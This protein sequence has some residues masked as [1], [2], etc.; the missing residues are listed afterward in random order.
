MKRVAATLALAVVLVGCGP[1]F[2]EPSL[3]EP[4]SLITTNGSPNNEGSCATVFASGPLVV[5]PTYGTAII[6]PS[7]HQPDTTRPI[8]VAWRPG[9][10]ARRLGSEVEVLDPQGN[11]VAITGHEYTLS[12]SYMGKNAGSPP[13]FPDRAFWVCRRPEVVDLS[14]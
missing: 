1:S 11:V 6:D 14:K 2:S 3:S 10:T 12:G 5:D 7:L 8:P 13:S 9:F 4:V